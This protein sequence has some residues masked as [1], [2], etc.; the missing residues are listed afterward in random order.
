MINFSLRIW[1]KQHRLVVGE[2]L[3]A[4]AMTACTAPTSQPLAVNTPSPASPSNDPSLV[5]HTQNAAAEPL[6][7]QAVQVI[8]D[9]YSAIARGDYK[10]AYSAWYG[11][12]TASQQS[13]EQ[14]KQGFANT[15]S[16]AVKVG[17]PGKIDGAAG[18][19]YIK[20]P[21]TVTAITKNG[22]QQRFRGSYVLRRVNNVPGSTPNQR[23]WHLYSANIAP[24]N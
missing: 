23:R 18:S 4:I 20:I 15:K 14:F 6:E 17:E 8:R 13:F 10:Q 3:L 12:G 1:L 24:V 7:Q 16:T 9:Y 22:T 5:S 19:S 2:M 21:V 11:D